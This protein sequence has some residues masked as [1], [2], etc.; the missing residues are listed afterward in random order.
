MEMVA[1]EGEVER[2]DARI[3]FWREVGLGESRV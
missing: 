3:R 2:G 1:A